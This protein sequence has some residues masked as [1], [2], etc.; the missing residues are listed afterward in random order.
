MNIAA[1]SVRFCAVAVLFCLQTCLL[2]GQFESGTVLGSIHD[3]SGA[4]VPNASV[5]LEDVQTRVSYSTRSDA[6]ENMSS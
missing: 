6:T 1:K 2:F 5:T 4:A 3:P